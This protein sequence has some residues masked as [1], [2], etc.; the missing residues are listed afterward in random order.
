MNL[1]IKKLVV[2]ALALSVFMTGILSACSSNKPENSPVPTAAPTVAANKTPDPVS[3]KIMLFGDKPARL[4]Q[5]A[6]QIRGNH[7]GYTEYK[8]RI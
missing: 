4:G 7:Q 1:K 2:P 5:G 8:T 6:G 3:L